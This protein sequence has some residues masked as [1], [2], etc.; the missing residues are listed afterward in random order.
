MYLDNFQIQLVSQEG[1]IQKVISENDC[2]HEASQK[3][4]FANNIPISSSQVGEPMQ[5]VVNLDEFYTKLK[6]L[7]SNRPFTAPQ[8]PVTKEK[9]KSKDKKAVKARVD[10]NAC[11]KKKEE[12]VEQFIFKT[13]NSTQKKFSKI[14]RPVTSVKYD[15]SKV[16]DFFRIT[17]E[18]KLTPLA[19]RT[20]SRTRSGSKPPWRT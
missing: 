2:N 18:S 10:F 19:S 20:P 13:P 8:F 3:D 7:S 5:T 1:E 9:S 12:D 11:I 14:P 17:R 16:L 4:N 15:A 6:L